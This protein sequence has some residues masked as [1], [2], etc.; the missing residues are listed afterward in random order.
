MSPNGRTSR[1]KGARGELEVRDVLRKH[2]FTCE[3]GA[4]YENDLVHN[5]KGFHFEV[6][7]RET[8]DL[9]AWTRQA[10]RDS[11]EGEVPCVAYRKTREPWRVSLPLETLLE[12]LRWQKRAQEAIDEVLAREA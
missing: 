7:R 9:P 5:I 1:S 8:L 12:L 4:R 10:E 11:G 2:G 6:K 3:R